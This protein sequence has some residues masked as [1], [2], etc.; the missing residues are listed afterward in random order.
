MGIA[1]EDASSATEDAVP[2]DSAA[3]WAGGHCATGGACSSGE[4]Q[5]FGSLSVGDYAAA[6]DFFNEGVDAGPAGI[7]GALFCNAC[8][9]ARRK[10][11]SRV[12]FALHLGS[13]VAHL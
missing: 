11:S 6:R 10:I 9:C 13:N 1:E 3:G 2:G 4:A 12:L 5:P 7:F 8:S